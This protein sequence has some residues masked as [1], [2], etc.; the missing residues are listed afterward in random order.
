[1]KPKQ[2]GLH[3]WK[4]LISRVGPH[5]SPSGQDVFEREWDVLVVLD[6]CRCDTFADVFDGLTD[7]IWSVGATSE[8]WIR[9]TF[10]GRDT[11]SVGM[12]TGNPFAAQLDADNFAH[13]HLEPVADVEGI[14]TVPPEM[15]TDR[16]IDVWRRRDQLGVDRLVVHFM[17][18]HVPFRSRPDWFAGWRGTDTWGSVAWRDMVAG[19][20]DRHEWFDAYRDNLRWV[21]ADVDR[22]THN[23][24]ATIAL[25]ADHGNAAGEWG[26]Y[27]HPVG[28]PISAVRSVPWATVDGADEQTAAP[29]HQPP[30]TSIDTDDQLAA[31]GY[32]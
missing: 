7:C 3:A 10:G 26:L 9:R 18:P 24:D 11:S 28:A 1:M 13:F 4:S 27:G 30:E 19:E 20:I 25:T 16:A 15:L 5:L 29:G 22:L 21:L 32:R 23:C 8:T 17:Q 6:G 31:L 2:R 14:E 12:L